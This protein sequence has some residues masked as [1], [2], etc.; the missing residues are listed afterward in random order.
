SGTLSKVECYYGTGGKLGFRGFNTVPAVVF[1][2]GLL[3]LNGGGGIDGV[4][5]MVSLELAKS[6]TAIAWTLTGVTPGGA[7]LSA[8]GNSGAR[9]ASPSG[10][11]SQVLAT[12][13]AAALTTTAAGFVV[14]QYALEPPSAVYQAIAGFAGE[15][16]SVRLARL[17][18]E[19]GLAFTLAANGKNTDT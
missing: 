4:P 6:G 18:A 8:A 17:A 5:V 16:A 11:V 9:V 14:L 19:A 12:P 10:A 13:G 1:D 3:L 7:V 2:S 15:L